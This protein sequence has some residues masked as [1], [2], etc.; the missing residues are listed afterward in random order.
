MVLASRGCERPCGPA[1]GPG[2]SAALA[3]RHLGPVLP[4]E[5][6]LFSLTQ[7]TFQPFPLPF[8]CPL[9]NSAHAGGVGG[10]QGGRTCPPPSQGSLNSLHPSSFRSVPAP[11]RPCR[12]WG[13]PCFPVLGPLPRLPAARLQRVVGQTVIEPT[14]PTP[15][16]LRLRGGKGTRF[17][18]CTNV[19]CGLVASLAVRNDF[20]PPQP[21]RGEATGAGG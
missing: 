16:R 14:P 17:L 18:V 12:S 21:S 15:R 13:W 9:L 3:L 7:V 19:P 5:G 11:P 4:P 8:L 6:L 20:S 1:D 2:L 10:G